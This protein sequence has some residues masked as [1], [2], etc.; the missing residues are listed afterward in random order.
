MKIVIIS[1]DQYPFFVNIVNQL[2]ILGHEL[3]VICSKKIGSIKGVELVSDKIILYPEYY[4]KI[5]IEGSKLNFFWSLF[6]IIRFRKLV[7]Q[8][9][10]DILHAFNLKWSGWFAAF[11]G[12]H[13]YILSG[14]GSDIL[15]EQGA[16]KNFYLRFL[17][18]FTIKKV[19]IV[20]IVSEQ[21]EKQ[22]K[23]VNNS[24]KT[25]FLNAGVD[26]QIFRSQ[27]SGSLSDFKHRIT[28]N[29]DVKLIFSPRQIRPVY[30]IKQII[31]AFD[32]VHQ[33][34]PNSMLIQGG[35][36]NTLYVTEVRD[37]INKKKLQNFVHFTGRVNQEDWI[38]YFSISDIVVSFPYNDGLPATIFEAMAIGKPLILSDIPSIRKLIGKDDESI[39][40]DKDSINQL[41]EGILLLIN[42]KIKQLANIEFSKKIFNKY[43]DDRNTIKVLL[44]IYNELIDIKMGEYRIE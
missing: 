26:K 18:K 3:H 20:T 41:A 44:K 34:Q 22:V 10:P 11:S 35:S 8:I 5:D 32:L 25:V 6:T 43:G 39:L 21:M 1:S 4:G 30:Q 13:P 23:E 24:T 28:Y 31:E 33:K 2:A 12:Y 9:Q 14:L 38:N 27:P 7:Q 15:I 37:L 36:D 29:P 17:R 42:N 19:D 16:T 40:V